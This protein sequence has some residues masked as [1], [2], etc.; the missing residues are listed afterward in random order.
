MNIKG[1][2]AICPHF[3]QPHFQLY[4]TK[5]KVF[6]SSYLNWLKILFTLSEI[7]NFYINIHFSGPF[8]YWIKSE[9]IE[10]CLQLEKLIRTKKIGIIGGF[11]D[12]AFIQ[13]STRPDDV[14]FQI[15]EYEKLTRELF[16]V[17]A[18]EWQ[19]FHLPERECG[20]F[21]ITR[22]TEA[23]KILG[24]SAIYYLDSETVFPCY[25]ANP[26]SD[27]DFCKRLFGLED[28]VSKTTISHYPK[29]MQRYAFRDVIGGSEFYTIPIHYE[30][31]Y[32]FLKYDEKTE[33]TPQIY[34]E[35]IK[36]ALVCASEHALAIGKD[37]AP[38]VVIF[39]DAEKFGDWSGQPD[40]DALWIK[41]FVRLICE[42]EEIQ[43]IG[44]KDYYLREGFFDTY[45]VSMSH[46][47]AEWENWTA[48]RGIRGVVYSDE[49][50]RKTV[51]LLHQLEKK[52]E[53]FEK[54]ILRKFSDISDE[55]LMAALFDSP[56]R[57]EYIFDT[58]SNCLGDE[59][60]ERYMLVHRIRNILYQ[61]DSKWAVR[62]PNYGSAPY[63]DNNGICYLEIAN[64]MLFKLQQMVSPENDIERL[65]L[66]EW[67]E[68]TRPRVVVRTNYQFVSI[69]PKGAGIDCHIALNQNHTVDNLFKM[70]RP[71]LIQMKSF[72][73][74][75]RLAVP[76]VFTE[77][78]S[79][80]C[81]RFDAFGERVERCR[82]SFEI[83][84]SKRKDCEFE[85]IVSSRDLDFSL[86][87][88]TD[89]NNG[90]CVVFKADSEL[91]VNG[92]IVGIRM[93]K[94]YFI[95]D[96]TVAAIISAELQ[97]VLPE[98]LFL[99]VDV[100][101][102]LTASDEVDFKPVQGVNVIDGQKN[103]NIVIKQTDRKELNEKCKSNGA[104]SY[105]YTIR[106]GA[107]D[108]FQNRIDYLFDSSTSISYIYVAPTINNY[109]ENFVGQEQSR[110]GYV[111]SGVMI[112]PY[113][114]LKK[115]KASLSINQSFKWDATEP[116][117]G[118][119][120]SLV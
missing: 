48:K 99:S 91:A 39:E 54:D 33:M 83:A 61:E 23:L 62:H 58:L 63:L 77:T 7:D 103:C 50:I 88:Q 6:D 86:I 114:K 29:T 89:S 4:K 78:D 22:T 117:S 13:L 79:R 73:S 85:Q 71:E 66:E 32:W 101:T 36:Q 118:L 49:K 44:L 97:D 116:G 51:G 35:N 108:L 100:I 111:A 27:V 76:V 120:F 28:P 115:G 11:A 40:K 43:M 45:P 81:Y 109:Y 20:E 47:Y 46:S 12:E 56:Y 110:L 82:K 106:T 90:C 18:S 112:T 2:V 95:T 31:R 52:I 113:V 37:I 53:C 68:D 57:Y 67:M 80:L 104:M 26:G 105:S 30:E 10:Y 69:D 87:E 74:I 70:V 8:L 59:F 14:L 93:I 19:G 92:S 119:Y 9:K 25:Y 38:I 60:S 41:E 16:G 94:K 72:P 55:R 96:T 1:Y 42:D 65:S 98:E 21:L 75:Y 17:D 102:S 5:E 34:L 24:A 107:S 15:K 3:H 64:R 84:L